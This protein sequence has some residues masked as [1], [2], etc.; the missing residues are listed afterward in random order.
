MA[1]YMEEFSRTAEI[2]NRG[3]QFRYSLLKRL[4]GI[5]ANYFFSCA[6]CAAFSAAF[7]A[8]FSRSIFASLQLR[9]ALRPIELGMEHKRT[10]DMETRLME[11]QIA[12]WCAA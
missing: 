2:Q 8:C 7:F 3:R 5:T 10:D 4:Y 11:E 1:V 6:S 12:Q 9:Y